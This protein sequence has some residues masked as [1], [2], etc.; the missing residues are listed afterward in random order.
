MILIAKIKLKY[1]TQDQRWKLFWTSCVVLFFFVSFLFAPNNFYFFNFK[2]CVSVVTIFF[3]F[4]KY[5]TCWLCWNK[6]ERSDKSFLL[7][8][9]NTREVPIFV[10]IALCVFL[11]ISGIFC[12]QKRIRNPKPS[13]IKANNCQLQRMSS[14]LAKDNLRRKL[15]SVSCVLRSSTFFSISFE[16]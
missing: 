15:T 10:L 5:W 12:S 8:A 7:V 6:R 13:R 3:L 9:I 2:H 4:L 11:L 1:G 14:L 16:I